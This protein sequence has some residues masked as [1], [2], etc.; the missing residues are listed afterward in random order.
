[1]D[2]RA[3][4]SVMAEYTLIRAAGR[5]CRTVRVLV[6]R[7]VWNNAV[8][9]IFVLE[10]MIEIL[11]PAQTFFFLFVVDIGDTFLGDGCCQRVD[12]SNKDA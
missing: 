8:S 2:G 7:S 1:M 9:G 6:K 12:E 10:S 4:D 3:A 5:S 11:Q